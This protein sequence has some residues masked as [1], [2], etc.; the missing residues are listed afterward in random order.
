M[1]EITIR[2]SDLDLYCEVKLLNE[3]TKFLNTN[4]FINSN[5]NYS[6]FL[7]YFLEKRKR[8]RGIE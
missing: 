2:E 1:K 4:D 5:E 7:K 8:S 6:K 3:Y